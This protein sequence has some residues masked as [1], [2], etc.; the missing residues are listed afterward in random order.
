[1]KFGT[2]NSLLQK[3]FFYESNKYDSGC[4]KDSV[5]PTG[6]HVVN[7]RS[8]NNKTHQSFNVCP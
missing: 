6:A 8:L 7:N 5:A 1:M 3:Q 2:L 4:A